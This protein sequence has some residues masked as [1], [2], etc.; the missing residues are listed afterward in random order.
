MTVKELY[1]KALELPLSPGVYVMRDE[2]ADV[3][4]VGKAKK[5]KN[6]VSQYFTR[7]S[8][9]TPKTLQMVKSV[10]DFEVLNAP[11]ELD[12]L[13]LENTLI[14]KYKPKYNILLKDDKGYPFIKLSKGD[15][16]RFSVESKRDGEGR[17][18]GPFGGR[19]TANA[20]LRTVNGLFLLP[21]C[22]RVFPRDIGKGRPCLEYDIGKC[23]GVCTGNITAAEYADR[24]EKAARVFEGRGA[25]VEKK[26]SADMENAAEKLD[27]EEAARL[28][29]RLRALSALRQSNVV[30]AGGADTDALGF[31][32][33]GRRG[34]VACLSYKNGSLIDKRVVFYDGADESDRARDVAA[35]I[36]LY[37]G[38]GAPLPRELLLPC[39]PEDAEGLSETVGSFSAN[40]K[41]C[42]LTVPK[43]GAKKRA[44]ELAEQ[45]AR[46]ELLFAERTEQKSSKTVA[47]LE[48]T[49]GVKEIKRIEA[50]DISHTAGSDPVGSQVVFEGFS[51]LK[52]D[53]KK[54]RIKLAVPGDDAAA[55][56]EVLS[57]RLSR[58][59]EGDEA[60]LP[61]P[62]LILTDGGVIQVLAALSQVEKYGFSIPVFGM[63]KDD[64]H[65]TRALVDKEGRETGLSG[66][67]P[68]FAFIGRIQ[69]EVHRFAITYHKKLHSKNA[70]SSTLTEIKGVGKARADKLLKRFKSVQGIKNAGLGELSGVVGKACAADIKNYFEE[71]GK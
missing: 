34:C 11:T 43:K 55:M 71:K 56:A 25:E 58:A 26:L 54:Y 65:R 44:V 22:S 47:L 32:A 45:N 33:S 6:R 48:K 63:V 31:H 15:F 2:N 30:C 1:K 70:L 38:T 13:L 9:H 7:L 16:P 17:F 27:F 4:Y 24:I 57:R 42:L 61:L 52:R 21:T 28:R 19:G 41:K 50:Y 68:L 3:I 20:A 18:F 53:Y 8:S 51:P 69:E 59:K 12:A 29:D 37:Y 40:G 5:L 60:F 64:R 35:F 67:P 66:T 39:E 23:C 62:D 14:K 46:Q 36:E 10:S 49:I